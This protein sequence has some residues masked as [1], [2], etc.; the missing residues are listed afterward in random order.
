ME[1]ILKELEERGLINLIITQNIDGLHEAAGSKK[2]INLHG[3]GTKFYCVHCRKDYTAEEY[4]N[5]Y[6]V[7]DENGEEKVVLKTM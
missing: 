3:D 4:K 2:V 7:V 6:D 1:N 5:G